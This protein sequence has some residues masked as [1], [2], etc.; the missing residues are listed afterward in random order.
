MRNP[1]LSAYSPLP[2]TLI[3]AACGGLDSNATHLQTMTPAK[4]MPPSAGNVGLGIAPDRE[5]AAIAALRA[6]G[7]PALDQLLAAYD[8]MADGPGRASL[9]ATID[10]VAAQRYATVSRL[11]W[12]TDLAA[13]RAEAK[14]T[15]KPILSL[16]MLG[17]L[18]EDLSCANSRFFRTILYPD[19][20]IAKKLREKF[21]LHWSPERPVPRVTI[22]FGD[23]RKLERTVTGNSI[24]YVLDAG[25]QVIDAL[26]GMY[27]PSV[28][29]D[30]LEKS[31]AL[32]RELKSVSTGEQ[33]SVLREYHDGR[34]AEMDA[35]W[36]K[37]GGTITFDIGADR[38]LFGDAATSALALAQRATMS[39][40]RVEAPEIAQIDVGAD[41]AALMP[42]VATWAMIGQ[43]MFGLAPAAPVAAVAP[44]RVGSFGAPTKARRKGAGTAQAKTP[45]AS[46][47][48]LSAP[49]R[50]LIVRVMQGSASDVE[51]VL[52]D[53]ERSVIADTAI[54]E[55]VLRRQLS[56]MFTQSGGPIAFDEIN[57][58]AYDKLFATPSEDKWLGLLP[59]NVYTGLPADGI[60]VPR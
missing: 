29:S 42:D 19:P 48:L 43:T 10:A 55:L 45:P 7:R 30:E 5:A 28:F 3:A 50:A 40:V 27:A 32:H 60:V 46:L 26:P 31:L 1:R 59:D 25:G 38:V 21:V 20:A 51:R 56:W 53:L 49:A 17:R 41:P 24:H 36:A 44:E 6:E 2:L 18:D 47:D 9:A 23:G 54:N 22:D 16:R 14:A 13:A 35:R 52:P 57:R 8:E 11:Y 39:K 4:P 34:I 15:G 33:G 12:F 58:F 37:L